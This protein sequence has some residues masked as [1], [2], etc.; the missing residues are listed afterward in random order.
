VNKQPEKTQATK[1]RIAEAFFSVYETAPIN[2]IRII[3]ITKAADC[4]RS[5]FYEYFR[6]IYDVLDYIE[7]RIIQDVK[8]TAMQYAENNDADHLPQIADI[9]KRNG[10]YI[11][12]L[13]G[14]SGDPKFLELFKDA[15]YTSFLTKEHL[16]DSAAAG[17]IY[18]YSLTG[19][20]MGFRWWYLHQESM[21]LDEFIDIMQSLVVRGTFE[22][23]AGY[24]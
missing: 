16:S 24:C 14:D 2:K 19:L 21:S 5:T 8:V 13:L 22:T 9:Y 10:R 15:L 12:C 11:C 23:L 6:D 1:N 17:I 4:N 3:D 20:I 7:G 18:E